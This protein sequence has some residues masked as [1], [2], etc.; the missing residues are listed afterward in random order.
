MTHGSPRA[1]IEA[2]E[3]KQPPVIILQFIHIAGPLKGK[4]EEFADDRVLVGRHPSCQ[5]RFPPDLTLISRHHAEI[6]REGNRIRLVD[7]STN[8]TL[9]NGKPVAEA[10]LKNGDVLTFAEGGPKVSFLMQLRETSSGARISPSRTGAPEPASPVRE[11]FGAP[12][13]PGAGLQ[14]EPIPNSPAGQAQA[15]LVV[16]YGPTLRTFRRFPVTLG[17]GGKCEIVFP[18]ASLQERHA[19]ILVARGRYCVKDL[20]GMGIVRV[21]GRPAGDQAPLEPETVLSLGPDGPTFRFLGEGR[22]VEIPK[23][24]SFPPSSS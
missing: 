24:D 20:T 9:L 19:Q 7:K 5:L 13:P 6:I 10:Q 4:I 15:V 3:M 14:K 23:P 11:E 17:K 22:L 12:P 21:D 1:I 16:Q 8:G 18:Q 2:T